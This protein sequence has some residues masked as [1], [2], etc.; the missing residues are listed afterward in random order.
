MNWINSIDSMEVVLS[1][2][3]N[4]I[5]FKGATHN[6]LGILFNPGRSFE[7]VRSNLIDQRLAVARFLKIVAVFQLHGFQ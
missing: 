2:D 1:G 5:V 7:T 6:L 3:L 4:I